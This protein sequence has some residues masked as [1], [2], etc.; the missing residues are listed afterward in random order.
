MTA[1]YREH[2]VAKSPSIQPREIFDLSSQVAR[3]S[4]SSK[5][6]SFWT[7]WETSPTPQ[8]ENWIALRTSG[9]L[10]RG[11]SWQMA[12][13]NFADFNVLLTLSVNW[14]KDGNVVL[15]I[16]WPLPLAWPGLAFA[17][18][19]LQRMFAEFGLFL[20]PRVVQ[21]VGGRGVGAWPSRR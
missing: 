10:E 6:L 4:S 8:P 19:E 15:N 20:C 14:L 9:L 18:V 16:Y 3:G 12:G 2:C 1:G 7:L 17:R 13:D 21:Y 11:F 5:N